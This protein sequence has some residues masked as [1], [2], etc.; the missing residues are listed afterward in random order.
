KRQRQGGEEDQTSGWHDSA[1]SQVARGHAGGWLVVGRR[2]AARK[3]LHAL[4]G[5]RRAEDDAD[6]YAAADHTP[7][8]SA[9][10]MSPDFCGVCRLTST[11]HHSKRLQAETKMK[12][13]CGFIMIVFCRKK[14]NQ[15]NAGFP[16]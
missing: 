13:L 3:R 10:L 11:S 6:R 9:P 7:H 15:E 5:R 14:G 2:L 12:S 16:S 8:E 1:P 4:R